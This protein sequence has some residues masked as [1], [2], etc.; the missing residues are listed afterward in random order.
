MEDPSDRRREVCWNYDSGLEAGSCAPG[1]TYIQTQHTQLQAEVSPGRNRVYYLIG[2][3]TVV[4]D[5]LFP[6]L[7]VGERL[8]PELDEQFV[9]KPDRKS[10]DTM[11]ASDLRKAFNEVNSKLTAAFEALP[12]GDWLK[13]HAAVSDEDFLKEPLRN[14]LAVLQ[15]R[16]GH[17]MFHAGQIRLMK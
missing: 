5:R 7:A 9:N 8:H 11:S 13:K 1:P 12:T 3:L 2:H 6:M 4:H 14:R 17:A 16:T 10:S 15:S